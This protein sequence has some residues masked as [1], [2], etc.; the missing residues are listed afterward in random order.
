V[1]YRTV[2]FDSHPRGRSRLE[3]KTAVVHQEFDVEEAPPPH[4]DY[5][6]YCV[7]GDWLFLSGV[8]P[9]N[10]KMPFDPSQPFHE[11][12]DMVFANVE[13]ILSDAQSRHHADTNLIEVE[14]YLT[15]PANRQHFN[16][17]YRERFSE[18]PHV[19]CVAAL[20]GEIA[21]ELKVV[22]QLLRFGGN[23]QEPVSRA[24]LG[25]RVVKRSRERPPLVRV[26][27]E[28]QEVES[29]LDFQQQ[30]DRAFAVL[31]AR[32]EDNGSQISN[33]LDVEVFLTNFSE[34][35]E[36]YNKAYEGRFP[37]PRP[38]RTTI[39][40]RG[41]PPNLSMTISARAYPV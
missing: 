10:P 37:R 22:G 30:F 34:N 5:P 7:Y 3:M 31:G 23:G 39:G 25:D 19:V 32:L 17:L 4:G 27:T 12:C 1:G 11:Q 28:R 2:R 38:A 24:A 9:R 16:D 18:P 36:S 20:P 14:A 15:D 21:I 29:G 8:G 6:H 40:V 35:W 33:V 13:H 26:S 41:L